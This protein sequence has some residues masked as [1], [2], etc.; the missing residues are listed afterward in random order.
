MVSGEKFDLVS[1]QKIVFVVEK[2]K[3]RNIS[4]IAAIDLYSN[5]FHE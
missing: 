1:E 3:Q 2:Q 5:V 4:R